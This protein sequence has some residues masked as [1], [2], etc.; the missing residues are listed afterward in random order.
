LGAGGI[1]RPTFIG[2]N[3]ARLPKTS[4]VDLRLSRGFKVHERVTAQVF[5]EA[6]NLFNHTNYTAANSTLYIAGGTPAAPTLT[7]NPTFGAL[8]NANNGTLGPTQRLLQFG[9][10][11]TF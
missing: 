1:N 6:F 4:E 11:V 9:A 3:S 7:F 5:A 10:R 8:T 2:R